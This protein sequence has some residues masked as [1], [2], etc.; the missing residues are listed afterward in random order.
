MKIMAGHINLTQAQLT[1]L[2]NEQVAAALA[3]AH[4]GATCL[5]FQELHGLSS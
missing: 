3:A 4:A 5:Y 1:A 2:I